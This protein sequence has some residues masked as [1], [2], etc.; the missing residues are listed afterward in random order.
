MRRKSLP[1]RIAKAPA[2]GWREE[3]CKTR[4]ELFGEKRNDPNVNALS[5]LSPYL[6]FGRQSP[7]A[8]QRRCLSEFQRVRMLSD[9]TLS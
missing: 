3:F 6:H 8:A 7:N 1:R 2:C 9:P 4:L 5:G